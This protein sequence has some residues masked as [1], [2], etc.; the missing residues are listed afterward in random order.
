MAH[1]PKIHYILIP[2]TFTGKAIFTKLLKS[3]TGLTMEERSDGRCCQMSCHPFLFGV[4]VVVVVGVVL[5]EYR[6]KDKYRSMNNNTIRMKMSR[7]FSNMCQ[8]VKD[9]MELKKVASDLWCGNGN[10]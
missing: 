6:N 4:V 9:K 3:L 1:F 2:F 7:N 5:A 8:K 10:G